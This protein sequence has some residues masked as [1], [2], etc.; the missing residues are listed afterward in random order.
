[1]WDLRLRHRADA[2]PAPV[3]RILG[4]LTERKKTDTYPA[5]E[6]DFHGRKR[7]QRV[8]PFFTVTNDL[9]VLATDVPPPAVT[10]HGA[11]RL[12]EHGAEPR[13]GAGAGAGPGG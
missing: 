4:D 8:K 12:P 6:R 5:V 7:P 11:A 3:G 9:A 13:A 10:E 1:M 2:D